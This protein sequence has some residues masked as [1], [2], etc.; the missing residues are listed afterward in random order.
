[1]E[2]KAGDRVELRKGHPCG[3]RIFEVTRIGMDVRLKCETC[4]S[5]ITLR[6]RDF[7]K[8]LKKILN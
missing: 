8:R 4:G 2:V 7:E 1:M 6:R 5:Y 3:G